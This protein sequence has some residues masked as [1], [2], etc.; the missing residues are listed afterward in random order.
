L[1]TTTANEIKYLG[2]DML[3]TM[4]SVTLEDVQKAMPTR[5]VYAWFW[6]YFPELEMYRA[7]MW[8]EIPFRD[9]DKCRYEKYVP[10]ELALSKGHVLRLLEES[11]SKEF[12]RGNPMKG[13]SRV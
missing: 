2:G 5:R 1:A 3:G 11:L 10:V 7:M 4:L 13:L 8:M 12:A 6:K 9:S